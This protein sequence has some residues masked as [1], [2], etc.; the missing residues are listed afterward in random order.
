MMKLSNLALAAGLLA[1]APIGASAQTLGVTTAGGDYAAGIK[2]AMWEP[3]AK[4]LG[5]DIL[6]ETQSDT[7]SA[8]RMQ[9]TSGAVTADVVHL[10]SDEGALGG[11]LNILEPIDYSVVDGDTLPEGAKAEFCFP[12]ASY[13]TVMAWNTDTYGDNGPKTWADF[14]DT[15][16]FP[17]RRALRANAQA[18]I[19]IALLADGVA[20]A[21][22]YN[23]LDTPEG[24]QRAIDKLAALKPDVAVWWTSGAQSTQILKDGEADLVITWNGRAENAIAD[25]AAAAFT[26]NG[27]VIGTDCLAVPKGAPHA[28]EAMKLIAGMTTAEAEAKLTDY[29]LY[30]PM[31]MAAYSGDL[32]P[33]DRLAKLATS[34]ENSA[35]S[36]Y[37]DSA[38]WTKNADA[39]QAAFDEMM[40]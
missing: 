35:S 3:A 8:V 14:W 19:E 16:K 32:I 22:V 5:Y 15:T 25:G 10:S 18:Q 21:E 24:L 27:S 17:G 20:P 34:P 39:A 23:V 12:F 36:V 31:N 37:I 13:G 38:W 4:A 30:G 40:Q 26:F 29:V 33:A 9:V 6:E 28:A 1:V 2:A 7:L 11:S